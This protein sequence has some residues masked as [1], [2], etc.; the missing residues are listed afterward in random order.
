MFNTIPLLMIDIGR[1]VSTASVLGTIQ[2]Y[3]GNIL[4]NSSFQEGQLL[5]KKQPHLGS[6]LYKRSVIPYIYCNGKTMSD[7]D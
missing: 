5:R 6:S 4:I 2:T 7:C 1:L 3:D